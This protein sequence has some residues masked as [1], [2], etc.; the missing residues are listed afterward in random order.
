MEVFDA[1][2]PQLPQA[3][4]RHTPFGGNKRHPRT[5]C[6]LPSQGYDNNFIPRITVL[7]LVSLGALLGLI[8]L[9]IHFVVPKRQARALNY[10]RDVLS[11]YN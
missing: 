9:M 10:Q 7:V 5:P 11:R 4:T 2:L 1:P 3:L 6:F 8:C